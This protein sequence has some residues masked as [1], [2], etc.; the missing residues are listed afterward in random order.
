ML[1]I[2]FSKKINFATS[3]RI[4]LMLFLLI[5]L[6]SPPIFS[7]NLP[8]ADG[9]KK[10]L[11][12]AY[13]DSQSPYFE[14]Y[15]N[16]VTPENA[17]KWG[18]IEGTRDQ[19]NWGKIDEAY[20]FAKDNGFP[21]RFHV[22][23]WGNQQPGWIEELDAESQLEE[24]EEWIAAVAERYPDI[25]YLEV[26]N[27]PLHD[28][29]DAGDGGYIDALGGSNNLYGTGWDWII[30][31]FELAKKYFPD[32]SGT[33]L[34]INDY[35]I[36]NNNGTTSKYL[37]IINLLIERNLID[38]IAI[39]GHAFSTRGSMQT[40]K[41]NLD[42]LGATGLP[43]QVSELD[44][45]GIDD[46]VQLDSYQRIFTTFWQHPSVEGI[47]LWG[48]RVGLWRSK[49]GAY[50]VTPDRGSPRPSLTWLRDYVNNPLIPIADS[51]S[52][53]E[54]KPLD[55][56][57][58][59]HSS[60]LATSYNLQV[61]STN[62]FTNIILDT[63]ITD[64]THLI[65]LMEYSTTYYWR[66]SA[67]NENGISEFSEEQSFLTGAISDIN[68]FDLNNLAFNLQQNYPNPF[69]PTTTIKFGLPSDASITLRIYD[70][71][72][73]EVATLF[74]NTDLSAGYHSVAWSGRNST[75]GKVTSGMYIYR[76]T[77]RNTGD[78]NFISTKKMIML[79]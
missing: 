12:C 17:G 15:W 52:I 77:A 29:P 70:I 63:T 62:L 32:S 48:W 76:L 60:Y 78:N 71:L 33:K 58:V 50:L 56:T 54:E 26:V 57:L 27:E 4:I 47:T 73:R 66:V 9:Q 40:I 34:Y 37:E 41:K 7:Q 61:A 59:W 31:S 13:S 22:L 39:Q 68:D 64:T 74:Q 72:G 36:P 65:N 10:F 46:Q 28:P 8:L 21:F 30:K 42:R 79:K 18:S 75:G 19:M 49:E 55:A 1:N 16:Q 51:T 6:F 25:D 35:S 69:N 24:I 38:G 23:I 3:I 2:F 20:N 53:A 45:D 14:R 43:I 44:I 67:I 11:G 5:G